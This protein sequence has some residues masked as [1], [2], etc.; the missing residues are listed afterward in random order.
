MEG[1]EARR[2]IF[3]DI[4]KKYFRG[5]VNPAS[6]I[7]RKK[8]ARA[9]GQAPGSPEIW[10]EAALSRLGEETCARVGEKFY[11]IDPAARDFLSSLFADLRSRGVNAVFYERLFRFRV[12]AFLDLGLSSREVLREYIKSSFAFVAGE[13]HFLL[14]NGETIYAEIGRGLRG[15]SYVPADELPGIFPMIPFDIA[16]RIAQDK[17]DYATLRD[18]SLLRAREFAFVEDEWREEIARIKREINAKGYSFVRDLNLSETR[19]LY[20]EIRDEVFKEILSRKIKSRGLDINGAVIG[21]AGAKLSLAKIVREFCNRAE[22]FSF[23]SLAEEFGPALKSLRDLTV[24]AQKA[25]IQTDEN[26]FVNIK[27]IRFAPRAMDAILLELLGDKPTPLASFSAFPLLPP[28][29]DFAWNPYLLRSY[30]LRA[31][32]LFA[33]AQP[34]PANAPIGLIYNRNKFGSPDYRDLV[35]LA[36]LAEG[37]APASE[38]LREFLARAKLYATVRKQTLEEIIARMEAPA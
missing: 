37:V 13:S 1:A 6:I 14:D 26:E 2:G 20:P 28:L 16:T 9:A 3:Y 33:V 30:F 5:G 24:I 29:G 21:P 17:F 10:S 12:E 36:A 8:F 34:A 38:S 23:A 27:K 18:G 35:A 31:S 32:G 11:A 15:R 4:V 19:A 7:D 25:A 22:R